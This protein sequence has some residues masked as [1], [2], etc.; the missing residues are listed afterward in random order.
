[1]DVELGPYRSCTPRPDP[2]PPLPRVDLSTKAAA[3]LAFLAGVYFG[4][5]SGAGTRES[6]PPET[7]ASYEEPN[8]LMCLEAS[9]VIYTMLLPLNR[10][11]YVAPLVY[12][13]VAYLRPLGRPWDEYRSVLFA[14]ERLMAELRLSRRSYF[15]L[16][17]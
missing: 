15:V 2:C 6:E 9:P 5:C 10:G 12:P 7:D 14:R 4:P 1:M 16:W 13:P 3:M 8:R 11:W 17:P